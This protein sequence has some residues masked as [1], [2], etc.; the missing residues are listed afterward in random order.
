MRK[1]TFYE[2]QEDAQERK[3]ALVERLLKPKKQQAAPTKKVNDSR[4]VAA[5][6]NVAPRAPRNLQASVGLA[7][8]AFYDR[9]T[10]GVP[11][12][13]E[14]WLKKLANMMLEVSNSGGIH[15]ALMW[16]ARISSLAVA[17]SLAALERLAI[18]DLLGLRTLVYPVMPS[19]FYRLNHFLLDRPRLCELV[20]KLWV[21][22]PQGTHLAALRTDSDRRKAKFLGALLELDK[23][24]PETPYPTTAEVLPSFIFR[25]ESEGWGDYQHR[26]L[27]RSITRLRWHHR[28]DIRNDAF[29]FVGSPQTASDALF[30]IA[31]GT[32]KE[33]WKKALGS[34]PFAK[35][36]RKPELLLID[37][38][39]EMREKDR[40]LSKRIPDFIVTAKETLHDEPGTLIVTDNPATFFILKKSLTDDLKLHVESHVIVNEFAGTGFS[41]KPHPDDYVPAERSLRHYGFEILDR[42]AAGVASKLLSL[43][44]TLADKPTAA[45][46]CND[47]AYYVLQLCHLPGGYRDLGQWLEA[48]DRPEFVRSRLAW[49]TH[50]ARLRGLMQAGG[51]DAHAHDVDVAL[52]KAGK[53]VADSWLEATPVALRLAKELGPIA[54][55]P[56]KQALVVLLKGPY[57][58]IA[59]QFLRRH[60]ASSTPFE[61]FEPRVTFITHWELKNHLR[62]IANCDRV[63][64]VGMNDRLLR[65]LVTSEE[66]PAGSTVLISYAQAE[67]YKR[68][69]LSLKSIEALKPF[70]GRISGMADE[71]ETRL[72]KIPN[73]LPVDRLPA[74]GLSVNFESTSYTPEHA[75]QE[76][77]RLDLEGAGRIF[78]SKRVFQYRPD[79][80][81]PFVSTAV[82]DIE[83][84]DSIFVMSDELRDLVEATLSDA[85]FTAFKKGHTFA[86]MLDLYHE[87]V[88]RRSK[89]LYPTKNQRERAQKILCR[90]AEID[91]KTKDCSLQRVLHWLDL[92]EDVPHQRPQA[93][94]DRAHFEAFVRAL[95]IP[96]AL[97]KD[98]WVLAINMTRNESR[99]A[100]REMADFYTNVIFHPESLQV[101]HKVA[102]ESLARLIRAATD[103]VYRVTAKIPPLQPAGRKSRGKN[104]S[105]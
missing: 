41:D 82:S 103:S 46:A 44:K 23:R 67:T 102:P 1:K 69:L 64:F 50:E 65:L 60:F 19:S 2:T 26:L 72:K 90:M 8:V 31:Y 15:I 48:D 63:F 28:E 97:Y 79:D 53:L 13:P 95:E 12:L 6:E 55:K 96:D 104:E 42:E 62:T 45:E 71:L 76:L 35:H 98:F 70:K 11:L 18:R 68:A 5:S 87:E 66:I 86:G 85:G 100:G 52:G 77:W 58:D 51:L 22:G 47:A 9:E 56:N 30:G 32:K 49:A 38:T 7:G 59:R 88:K 33:V 81:P 93:A 14:P 17:H 39:D 73:P 10:P 92:D 27:L 99:L 24:E 57:I 34:A 40:R 43:A 84:G 80:D 3:K 54:T 89:E 36:G 4:P 105:A 29:P 83:V 94:R 37:A 75:Q 74:Q 25:P 78:V 21:T 91:P 16:P 101:Y 61:N 20:R